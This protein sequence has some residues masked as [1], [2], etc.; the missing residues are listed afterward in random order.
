MPRRPRETRNGQLWCSGCDQWLHPSRFRPSEKGHGS[1]A[2]FHSQCRA[3]EQSNRT[4]R[5]NEDRALAII[6]SRASNIARRAHVPLEFVMNDLN[7]RS[8]VVPLRAVLDHPE[9]AVCGNCGHGYI[10]E[11]DCQLDHREPPRHDQDFARLHATNVTL[12]CASCNTS[13]G[14]REYSVW[15]DEQEQT[16]RSV[17]A[18]YGLGTAEPVHPAENINTGTLF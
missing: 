14:N 3:C 9:D 16:R 10:N 18:Y 2:R 6:R 17:A 8:L 4:D 7:Y 5:K 1:V 13:K 11:R 15:L 12:V